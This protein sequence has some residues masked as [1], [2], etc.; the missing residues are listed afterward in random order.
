[1]RTIASA[2]LILALT[3]CGGAGAPAN[4]STGAT[5]PSTPAVSAPAVDVPTVPASPTPGDGAALPD[6]S[7]SN[8]TELTQRVGTAVAAELG[9]DAGALQLQSS[10]QQEWPDSGIGC[11]APDTMYAQV[12]TPGYL[13]V[14]TDGTQTYNIHTDLDG[15]QAVLCE[16]GSP[17]NIPLP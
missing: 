17:T 4:D 13:M 8:E 7:A 12:I 11:P 10:E 1:M 5:N 14:F 9:L 15:S 2:F 6:S 3:A 16:N